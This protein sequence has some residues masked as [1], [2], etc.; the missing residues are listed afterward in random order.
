VEIEGFDEVVGMIALA[1][2][3]YDMGRYDIVEQCLSNVLC[4]EAWFENI[5]GAITAVFSGF[6]NSYND[7]DEVETMIFTDDLISDYFAYA[8]E[9]GVSTN[10]P[11]DENPYVLAA[12][13]EVQRQ[14]S[15]CYSMGWNLLGYTKT[16]RTAR[17]SKLIVYLGTCDCNC[18]T[19]LAYGL[20]RLYKWFA[21]QVAG[22]AKPVE[23]MAA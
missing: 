17:Q 22:F 21:D 7:D 15:Y 14:L 18:H 19:K 5:W 10:T 3:L 1:K 20:V 8:W 23:V 2:E 12:E 4:Y 16:K 9:F 11:H 6:C 13:R